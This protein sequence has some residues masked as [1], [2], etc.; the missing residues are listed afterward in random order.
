[1]QS[2][3]ER[4]IYRRILLKKKIHNKTTKPHKQHL[5]F[6]SM[7]YNEL[8]SILLCVSAHI[9]ICWPRSVNDFSPF[10]K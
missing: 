6:P 3:T 2:P 7:V 5:H 8:V 4:N 10:L 1:M 9:S